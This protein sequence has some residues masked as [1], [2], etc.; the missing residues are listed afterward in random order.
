[1]RDRNAGGARGVLAR[2]IDVEPG[3][4][5][6]HHRV[7]SWQH[8]LAQFDPLDR[9][10]GDCGSSGGATTGI[11]RPTF[12]ISSTVSCAAARR[13]SG[14]LGVQ[15]RGSRACSH[16][17]ARAHHR[18]RARRARSAAAPGAGASDLAYLRL[19]AFTDVNW[20]LALPRAGSAAFLTSDRVFD[21]SRARHDLAYAPASASATRYAGPSPGIASVAW[22]EMLQRNARICVKTFEPSHS[23]GRRFIRVPPTL[24]RRQPCW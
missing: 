6:D 2:G 16:G 19:N 23:D 22:C 24:V 9:Q 3:D 7:R 18:E 17:R 8:Q 14:P 12:P 20:S 10:T 13:R 21:L 11:T 1:M 5:P 4:R 15:P